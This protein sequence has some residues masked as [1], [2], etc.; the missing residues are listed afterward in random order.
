MQAIAVQVIGSLFFY[1]TSVYLS[2]S[3]FGTISW[4]N[5]VCLLITAFLGFGLEQIVIRRVATSSLSDWAASAF[6]LHSVAG[7]AITFLLLLLL[8]STTASIGFL[9]WFFLAQGIIYIGIPLKSFLNAKE[10]FTPYGIIAIVS[11]VCK[12]I[13]VFFLLHI[14]RLNLLAVINILI[15]TAVFE[16]LCLIFYLI[17]QTDFSFKFRVSAYTKLLK[18]ALPQYVSVIFDIGLSR[19]DWILLGIMSTNIVLADY[20]FAY[21]AFELSRLPIVVISAIILPRLARLMSVHNNA[22]SSKQ[23]LINSFVRVELFFAML[24]PLTLNILWAP[25]ITLI[26]KGKY[27]STNAVQFA[28]L[29]MCIP[30]QFFINVLWSISF[31]AK[32][33]KQVSG[34]TIS[35]AIINIILNLVFIPQMGGVGAAIAFLL[36]TLIQA[37]LYYKLVNKSMMS[38]AIGPAIIFITT[39]I[40]VYAVTSLIH[41]HYLIQLIIAISAYLCILVLLRQ[42][43]R[44]HWFNFKLF[45]G[46]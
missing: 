25:L 1:F 16:W 12:I 34:I 15:A 45:L 39:A 35:S 38:I 42:I 36:A 11:N 8:R 4:M 46:Q 23:Q 26:T 9:P 18:E 21:R 30:L 40:A 29:S 37:G 24:I 5:A 13:A 6:L 2:K 14:N 10:Q 19:M 7:F 27:G 31:G 44:Q 28:I 33:Y 3:D 17:T 43:N 20:S 41:V 22:D 32:K